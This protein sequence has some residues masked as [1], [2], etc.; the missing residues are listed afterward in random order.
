MV[1]NTMTFQTGWETRAN[2]TSCCHGKCAWRELA[3]CAIAEARRGIGRSVLADVYQLGVFR[4]TSMRFLDARLEASFDFWGLDSFKGLPHTFE[5][6]RFED[7][8]VDYSWHAGDYAADP[9]NQLTKKLQRNVNFIGGFFNVS[10]LDNG[11]ATEMRPAAYIDVDVDLYES[12]RDSLDFLFR[13]RLVRPGTVIGYDDWWVLTCCDGAQSP[14]N[15]G[16]G[17]AHAEMAEKYNVAL[18]CIGGSCMLP[19]R[20]NAGCQ[21]HRHAWGALFVVQADH[22]PSHGVWHREMDIEEFRKRN[23]Q[24]RNCAA[25]Y[26]RRASA[27]I[28]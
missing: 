13:N 3:V 2:C 20:E 5:S 23:S 19:R 4:G 16:E 11:L 1:S 18:K 7:S 27:A 24:C 9:R 21:T 12:A 14:L 28:S 17:R 25:R 6:P 8:S 22:R 10:L 26:R 15:G